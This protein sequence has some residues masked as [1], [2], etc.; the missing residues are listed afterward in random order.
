MA[1]T[2]CSSM[3][4]VVRALTPG[5]YSRQYEVR[6]GGTQQGRTYR[7]TVQV[8]RS[9]PFS[10]QDGGRSIAARALLFVKFLPRRKKSLGRCSYPSDFG[11]MQE[12]GTD[13]RV[14]GKYLHAWSVQ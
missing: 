1:L 7:R 14:D 13:S 9:H 6:F 5:R 10:L 3:D 8:P 12:D 4:T 11:G 2:G